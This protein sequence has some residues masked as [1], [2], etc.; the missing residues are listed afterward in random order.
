[1][2]R[3]QDMAETIPNNDIKIEKTPLNFTASPGNQKPKWI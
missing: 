2:E 1:M 3:V